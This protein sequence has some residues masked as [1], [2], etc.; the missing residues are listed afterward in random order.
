VSAR[1]DLDA[2]E[3]CLGAFARIFARPD[4]DGLAA[5]FETYRLTQVQL[6]LSAL[7]LPTI[8]PGD[9]LDSVDLAA[10]R[11]SFERRDQVMWGASATYNTSHPDP[12]RRAAETQCAAR[13]IAAMGPLGVS[14]ATLCSG[15]RN[16]HDMWGRDL[17][18]ASE[19]AWR[20][21]RASLDELLPAAVAAGVMLAIE[22]EPANTVSDAT[23]AVRLVDEL[24][25]DAERIG[26]ILDS[27]NLIS[28]VD[29]ADHVSTLEHAFDVLGDRTI[30]LHAKDVVPWSQT[31]GGHGVVNYD[32]VARLHAGLPRRVP[33]II[34]DAT[35]TELP[36]VRELLARALHDR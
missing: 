18:T 7:G 32:L 6:N 29:A 4:A 33:L 14:A 15:S 24:G 2:V 35:E 5:A 19:A 28:D 26:F 3:R 31:L 16:P 9:D 10:I 36:G 17:D 12:A 23:R 25:N 21:F 22:P 27:A 13:Y 34:Q 8:P 11:A 30:C 20:D 1:P